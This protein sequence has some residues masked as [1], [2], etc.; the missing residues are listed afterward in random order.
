MFYDGWEQKA[1][2]VKTFFDQKNG[3]EIVRQEFGRREKLFLE[4]ALLATQGIHAHI[5]GKPA[6]Q[7]HDMDRSPIDRA[8]ILSDNGWCFRVNPDQSATS[9]ITMMNTAVAREASEQV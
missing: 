7:V 5:D 9:I 1:V 3:G 2:P 4:L 8:Y 6:Y